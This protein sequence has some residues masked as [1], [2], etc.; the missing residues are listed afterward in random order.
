MLQLGTCTDRDVEVSSLASF[1]F[2]A[3]YH[4]VCLRQSI[5]SAWPDYT[6]DHITPL[7]FTHSHTEQ[8][9]LVISSLIFSSFLAVYGLNL[10]SEWAE[11]F[12]LED[13]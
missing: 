7:R 5:S 9:S 2:A 4:H 13:I 3:D 11:D 8:H 12:S 6:R 1:S 10:D